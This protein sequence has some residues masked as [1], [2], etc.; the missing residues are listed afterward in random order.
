MT[1]T[2]EI[3]PIVPKVIGEV[4]NCPFCSAS[5]A[6]QKELDNHIAMEHPTGEAIEKP[7]VELPPR[8][9]LD[10]GE[11]KR[12]IYLVSPHGKLIAEGRKTMVVKSKKFDIG[13]EPLYLLEDKVCWGK[14]ILSDPREISSTEFE[15]DRPKHFVTDEEAFKRWGWKKDEP[16]YAYDVKQKEIY[17]RPKPVSIPKGIQTFVDSSNIKFLEGKSMT[18]SELEYF[19]AFAH[20]H[21]MQE[22]HDWLVDI[23]N[24]RQLP[25][26]GVDYLD[27]SLELLIQDWRSYDPM[28]LIETDRG[29][30]VVADDHRIVHAW[31]SDLKRGKK[32]MSPQFKNIGLEEQK[33]IVRNL[34]AKILEAFNKLDWKHESPLSSGTLDPSKIE[35][36]DLEEVDDL[37]CN[38]LSDEEVKI[39][40]SRLHKLYNEIGKVTEPLQ[41]A[42]IFCWKEMRQRDIPHDVDDPLTDASALEVVEYPTPRGFASKD[43]SV[44]VKDVL[45]CFPDKIILHDPPIQVH[46]VGHV[47]NEGSI[48]EGHDIDILFK[49]AFPDKR[50]INA[51]RK[52][53]ASKN[54]EIANRL[55]FVFDPNGPQIGFYIPVFKLS[56]S[57]VSPEEMI[58]HHPFEYLAKE[59]EVKLGVPFRNLKANSGLHK[60]EFFDPQELWT[61]WAASRIERGIVFEKKYDGMRFQVHKE[62]D[63]VKIITEDRQRDRADIFK[64]SVAELVSK[65]KGNVIFDSEMVEYNCRGK[66]VKDKEQICEAL[67]REQMIPWVTTTK[68]EMDDS[69]IVFHIHDC[70]WYGDKPLNNLPYIERLANRDKALPDGL[71]HWRRVPYWIA[72]NQKEFETDMQKART[73]PGSEGSMLKEK[74]SI[75]ELDGRTTAWAKIKNLKEIDVMV[76]DVIP[77]KSSK[78]G[79]VLPG[80]FMYD[81]VFAIPSSLKDKVKDPLEYQGKTYVMIGRSY[82]SNTKCQKGDII[83]VRPVRVAEFKTKDEKLFWTWMFPLVGGKKPKK[84][85]PDGLETIRKLVAMGTKVLSAEPFVLK[86]PICPVWDDSNTCPLKDRF[87]RPM[88]N[89]TGEKEEYLKFPIACTLAFTHKCRYV[90]P[91][92][93]GEKDTDMLTIVDEDE[94]MEDIA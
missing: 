56:Y 22:L 15:K 77:K 81:C 6:S 85:E 79:A 42:H 25:H 52:A 50:I 69:G 57:K 14:I 27:R 16:L 61:E 19:H 72:T 70:L 37:Y 41:N 36:K 89:L 66:E 71:E 10:I 67:P 1:S 48:P 75:Y 58:Q 8:D 59:K 87:A 84:K 49:Q 29:K 4:F 12:G 62:G 86:L 11:P 90:K 53:V 83:L 51:F 82:S 68:R 55:H 30:K 26:I 2:E 18:S 20:G 94:D 5:F 92:Y 13:Y 54:P 24:I 44:T 21:K 73:I 74:D 63:T 34:H 32:L 47:V 17:S 76:W 31:Y 43:S 60:F 39:L 78:T 88:D 40:D 45:S 7:K 91:Y 64:K 28:K 46:L 23:Y 80:Q 38:D 33:K 3:Q 65:V 93:Y 9:Q 35:Q